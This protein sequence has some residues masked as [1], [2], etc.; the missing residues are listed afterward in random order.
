VGVDDAAAA[1]G[2]VRTGEATVEQTPGVV[3]A[4]AVAVGLVLGDE[5]TGEGEAVELGQVRQVV[6]GGDVMLV[7]PVPYVLEASLGD[8]DPGEGGRDGT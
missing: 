7:R 5:Q 2:L 6:G 8:L 3:E 1:S 4:G